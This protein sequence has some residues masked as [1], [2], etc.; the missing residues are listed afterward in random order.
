MAIALARLNE[1]HD[2]GRSAP[3]IFQTPERSL[4]R[5]QVV[6]TDHCVAALLQ[7]SGQGTSIKSLVINNDNRGL[8][9]RKYGFH[10]ALRTIQTGAKP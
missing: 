9:W 4:R 6:A 8:G 1:I 5:R 7:P 2:Q 10:R 3:L